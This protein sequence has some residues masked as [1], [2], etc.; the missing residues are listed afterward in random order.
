[1][2]KIRFLK[3]FYRTAHSWVT[4]RK[5]VQALA[6]FS[7]FFLIVGIHQAFISPPVAAALFQLD[8]LTSL[9]NILAS[10][11]VLIGSTLSLIVVLLTLVFGRVWCG[12]LCPFGTVLD[13]FSPAHKKKTKP[14]P[15]ESL[16]RIKFGILIGILFAALLGNLTLLVLDPLTLLFRTITISVWP[17]ID[18]AIIAI[19]EALFPVPFLQEP[20][21]EVDAFLRPSIFPVSPSFYRDALLYGAVFIAILLLNLISERF[22]CRYLCPLGGLLGLLSK[23]SI[24]KR[25]VKNACGNCKLCDRACPTGAVRVDQGFSSD[26]GECILCMQCVEDCPKNAI[27]FPVQLKP[28][29]WES[30]DPTRRQVFQWFGLAAV[31]LAIA[32]VDSISRLPHPHLIQPPGA[33][34]NEILSKCIR[35]GECI[36]ACP[37]SALQPSLTETGLQGFWTPVLVPRIGYCD[38]SCTACGNNCPVHAIPLLTLD[39]KRIQSIGKAYIDQ[40]RCIAWSDHQTC[41]VCEEMC[42]VPDKAISLEPAI[43]DLPNGEKLNIQ[44]PS[45]N[46]ERCIGCG[47]C[48][49]KCPVNGD[50][51]IRI[52]TLGYSL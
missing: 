49:Y 47:I 14:E 25:N 24:F 28:A 31:S 7:F 16:R 20:L 19:E 39:E 1:M 48:E 12:W 23:V 17:A 6:L 10:H 45:V 46:R 41:I 5:I 21:S 38:Y 9:A 35:C 13:V 29:A 2:M 32:K 43:I 15:P 50:A 51:A 22:W 52:Y 42:P 36:R 30:Y 37:T 8:P 33:R 26:P 44:Y 11:A 4:Y 3:W 40:N 34:E 18:Q 27:N